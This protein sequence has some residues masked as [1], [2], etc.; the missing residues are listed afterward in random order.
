MRLI[1]LI[2]LLFSIVNI[3]AE[4]NSPSA[5]EKRIAPVGTVNISNQ[6]PSLKEAPATTTAPAAA[7][8][9]TTTTETKTA[10]DKGQQIYQQ[11][12]SV[13]HATGVAGS[14]KLTDKADWAKRYQQG[15]DIL[16]AHVLNGYNAMPP[17]GTCGDCSK[18]D[19]QDAIEYMLGQSG[20]K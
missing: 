4:T 20:A 5:I 6:A 3:F 15:M 16:L 18:Q 19:L 9:T 13:C 10:E 2:L 14:P 11:Y 7:Q 12:C 1:L 17:K 8:Q